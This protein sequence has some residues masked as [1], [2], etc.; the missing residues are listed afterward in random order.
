MSKKNDT[1]TREYF[2]F[3]RSFEEALTDLDDSTRLTLY[4]A[5]ARY[6]LYG[7][8]PALTGLA[9]S[10]WVLMRPNLQNS[11]K[12]Y[13]NGAKGGAPKG[14]SNARKWKQ[15]TLKEVQNYCKEK[16]YAMSAE[17][18]FD[19]YESIGW[20]K[21]NRKYKTWQDAADGWE[22]RAIEYGE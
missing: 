6:G 11:R 9:R 12:Q 15:P 8:E 7:E 5:I 22:L 18:F 10:M 20:V 2:P 19:Y 3:F 17:G 21:Q 4:K 13:E 1:P 14:N 16:G